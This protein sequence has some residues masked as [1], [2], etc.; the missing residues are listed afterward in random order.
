MASANNIPRNMTSAGVK[1]LF[2]AS[3]KRGQNTLKGRGATG[4][5]LHL[6]R[7]EVGVTCGHTVLRLAQG[8]QIGAS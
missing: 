2:R 1:P 7:N 5:F 3:N 4:L 8:V 6:F